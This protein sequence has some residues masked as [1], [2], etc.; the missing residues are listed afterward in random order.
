MAESHQA[1]FNQRPPIRP[2]ALLPSRLL[3][4]YRWS[5][6]SFASFSNVA[7]NTM[8]ATMGRFS[9]VS[10]FAIPMAGPWASP[11][12]ASVSKE[13]VCCWEE[14][15]GVDTALVRITLYPLRPG[16]R[17]N[18]SRPWRALPTLLLAA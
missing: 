8:K 2:R 16:S 14:C 5:R 17:P 13:R 7:A 4:P 10:T 12:A 6:R 11:F 3:R 18:P 15:P 9:A 1:E